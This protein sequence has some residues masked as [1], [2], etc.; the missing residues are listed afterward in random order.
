VGPN[1][2]GKTTLLRIL[3]TLIPPSGGTARVAGFDVRRDAAEIRTR[4]GFMPDTFGGDEELR[5]D[6]YLEFFA[7]VYR[8]SREERLRT[9][10]G[11]LN[12]VDL[13]RYQ[14]LA[15]ANLSL[16]A[17]QRLSLGRAL[18]HNPEVLLLDEPV[19]GLD[20]RGRV[21]MREILKELGRMGKT[22]L[23]SS[24][25]LADLADICDRIVILEKGEATFSGTLEELKRQ[26]MPDRT[27]EV[28]VVE[29]TE[30][31]CTLLAQQPWARAVERAE[32]NRLLVTLSDPAVSPAEVSSTLF[33]AGF[34][35]S[36][37]LER[38]ADLEQAFLWMTRGAES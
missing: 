15:I 16:G 5:V 37:L 23:I 12:L 19:S 4:I 9:I 21:E 3:A 25:I 24:H 29:D 8:L 27:L 31:A 26:T 18:L 20:P 13:T 36:R 22:V 28:E 2:A 10:R 14:N 17:K 34:Q 32:N 35:I 38:E 6:S 7:H 1:G 33:E 11:I 30:R